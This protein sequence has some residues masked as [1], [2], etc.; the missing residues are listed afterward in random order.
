MARVRVLAREPA[1]APMVTSRI[2]PVKAAF[3]AAKPETGNA[4]PIEV[5]VGTA[6]GARKAAFRE[7][8]HAPQAKT[9]NPARQVVSQDYLPY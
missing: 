3:I 6:V 2:A 8:Q 1:K 9:D 4:H 5:R 7:T